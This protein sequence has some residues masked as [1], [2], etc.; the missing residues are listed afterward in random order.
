MAPRVRSRSANNGRPAAHLIAGVGRT[1]ELLDRRRCGIARSR[2]HREIT[3]IGVDVLPEQRDFE[4]AALRERGDLVD[5]LTE[6]PALFAAAHRGHDA[7]GTGIVATDLDRDPRR[8][9]MGSS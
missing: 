5:E 4:D 3:S 2:P 9:G 7:K 8:M 6:R 1:A